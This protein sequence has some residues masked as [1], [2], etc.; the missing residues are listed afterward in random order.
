MLPYRPND[1]VI[2]QSPSYA[3]GW[4]AV[5]WVRVF[6]F[7]E[8]P[9][10]F[11]IDFSSQEVATNALYIVPPT[12]FH[13]I[14]PSQK[15]KFWCIDIPTNKLSEN[16]A[17]LLNSLQFCYQKKIALHSVE[18]IVSFLNTVGN[19]VDDIV[20]L[21]RKSIATFL[22]QA[23]FDM[24]CFKRH[25]ALAKNL[26]TLLWSRDEKLEHLAINKIALE[27]CCS[28]KTL[29]R[30]CKSV[31]GQNAQNVLQYQMLLASLFMMHHCK[32]IAAIAKE[33]GFAD[34]K[35]FIKFIKRK[36]N[37]TP[38]QIIDLIHSNTID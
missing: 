21:L 32:D 1:I 11:S 30:T 36:A 14:S 15:C 10:A 38:K 31:F 3:F 2:A 7:I 19:K 8:M 28:T 24:D 13:F 37:H 22:E 33:L 26:M 27:L 5:L 20:P 6:V 29:S 16:E 34:K 17:D 23:R 4:Q 18:N 35:T 9:S 12:H 25:L